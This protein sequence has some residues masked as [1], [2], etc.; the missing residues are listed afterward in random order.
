LLPNSKQVDSAILKNFTFLFFITF[1]NSKIMN[2]KFSTV[3]FSAT[4]LCI[5]LNVQAQSW[6]LNGNT[7]PSG[8]WLG[9]TNQTPLILKVDA[10]EKMRIRSEQHSRVLISDEATPV[11]I[12]DAHP[13]RS[14]LFLGLEVKN[15]A[16]AS[17]YGGNTG[18]IAQSSYD[19]AGITFTG[20]SIGHLAGSGSWH[21]GGGGYGAGGSV[22]FSKSLGNSVGGSFS[23]KMVNATVGVTAFSTTP[24]II[25]GVY[26][27]IEGTTA[28]VSPDAVLTAIYGLDS[29]K[30]SDTWAGYFRG[31]GHFTDKV[32]IGSAPMIGNYG[33]Y[34]ENGILTEKVKVALKS[35]TQ[36]ADFVFAPQY[37]LRSL[38][39][40]ETFIK[41]NHHLPDVPS[42]EKVAK[43][44]LDLADMMKIQMQK[45]EELTL[46]LINQQKEIETLKADLKKAAQK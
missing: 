10:L 13:N 30:R 1:K 24:R 7:F 39:D 40:V 25:A 44:G 26:G 20:T 41:K 29:M 28:S 22:E 15:A 45:I 36:W 17:G 43:D 42:A 27:H 21:A 32:S 35:T 33:L 18:I 9:S 23:I 2:F 19:N 46:Y 37:K 16:P 11:G 31:K 14:S 38:S 6:M 5:A 8:S 4:F 12:Y 3:A 34:V